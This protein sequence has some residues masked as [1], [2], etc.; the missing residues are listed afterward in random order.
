MN[1]PHCRHVVGLNSCEA[2]AQNG[3][4]RNVNMTHETLWHMAYRHR[5]SISG[6]RKT[7]G[8]V[9]AAKSFGQ[10]FKSILAN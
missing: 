3:K 9:S 7:K 2:K 10:L 8:H 5:H 6:P 4:H 1:H